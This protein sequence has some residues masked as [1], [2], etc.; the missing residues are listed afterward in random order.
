MEIQK[1]KRI[2]DDLKNIDNF[3]GRYINNNIEHS[4]NQNND[5]EEDE[6]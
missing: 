2:G 4:A 6:R 3:L 1:I 5:E